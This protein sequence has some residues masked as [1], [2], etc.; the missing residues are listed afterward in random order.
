MNKTEKGRVSRRR[1][2]NWVAL[3]STAVALPAR[4]WA[5]VTRP[6]TAFGATAL[7]QALMALGETPTRHEGVIFTT[8]DIAE[9]G[10]VVPIRVEVDQTVLPKVSKVYVLVEMNPNPLAAV[11]DIASGTEVY[12]ETRVKVAQT[13]DLY[14]VVESD[15]QLFMASR[16]TK[17]TL[18]GCGG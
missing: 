17:V 7:D 2:L 13:G 18:G 16:E 4:A 10:A 14:A 8:P 6:D 12:I 11:F 3:L 15:G 9:N 5:A 1:L